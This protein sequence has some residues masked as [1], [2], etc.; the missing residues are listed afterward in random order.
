MENTFS[1]H[2]NHT[3]N[4]NAIEDILSGKTKIEY[5]P[6]LIS[7]FEADSAKE[8][9]SKIDLLALAVGLGS[10]VPP[11]ITR[12]MLLMQ[13]EK[14]SRTNFS[15]AP[16]LISRLLEFYQFD[17][18]P[19]VYIQGL[20][21][22]PTAHLLLPAFGTGKLYFQGYLLKAADVHD[23]FS[24]EPV[25]LPDYFPENLVQY[26]NL[27]LSYLIFNLNQIKKIFRYSAEILPEI[28]NDTN[29]YNLFSEQLGELETQLNQILNQTS[30]HDFDLVSLAYSLEKLLAHFSEYVFELIQEKS[31]LPTFKN[32]QVNN[33]IHLTSENLTQLLN[34]LAFENIAIYNRYRNTETNLT[35]DNFNQLAGQSYGMLK[36]LEVILALITIIRLLPTPGSQSS[37]PL[38][39]H[40]TTTYRNRVLSVIN[41][42]VF[43]ELI[44]KTVSFM[45]AT[46]STK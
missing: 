45:Y 18:L 42:G 43:S 17:I 41:E 30:E 32:F 15:F 33:L 40:L 46:V 29:G 26:P 20:P 8:L 16:A 36:N 10:E 34:K 27:D 39:E 2:S 35:G 11:E 1:L 21:D 23:I 14:L 38:P 24:W 13:A 28:G 19:Q 31:I 12:I 44:Q 25:F 22:S 9:Y 5:K 6:E 37:L 3:W 4:I 7:G